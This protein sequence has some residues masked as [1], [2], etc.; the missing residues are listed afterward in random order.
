[1]KN[2]VT[3]RGRSHDRVAIE[4]IAVP[5]LDSERREIVRRRS[6]ECANAPTISHQTLDDVRAD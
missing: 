4:K 2:R 6:H 1:V 3:S 5:R